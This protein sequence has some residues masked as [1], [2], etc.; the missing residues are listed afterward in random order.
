MTVLRPEAAI[1][2]LRPRVSLSRAAVLR[3]VRPLIAICIALGVWQFAVWYDEV[4]VYLVPGPIAIF[5]TLIKD[6]GTLSQ[7]LV[8]TLSV[9]LSALAA[10][11]VIGGGLA[12][13]FAQWEWIEESFFPFAVVMQVTPI[14]AV[15]PLIIIWVNN[16]RL[17]LLICAWLV[18]FFPILSNT[19]LGL[20]SADHN[21]RDLF[22]LY[23]A[24]RLS[25]LWRLRLPTA[26]PYF[27]AG[28]RISGGLSLI[29]AVVAEFVAGTGGTQ[30]GLAYRIL[31]SGFQ[32][33]I[34]RMFA[35]LAMISACGIVIFVCLSV[36]TYLLLRRWHESA[37]RPER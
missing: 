1:H 10:A 25:T 22:R 13:L 5:Q 23:R 34:P 30:S 35:A 20:N 24:S 8:I 21:M 28:L 12:V 6:W 7:S 15:A 31:E 29:G 32:L 26:L 3:F 36:V 27:L 11:A 33:N 9:S 14:V 18:A 2:L 37:V 19:T 17:S 16:T 4:P